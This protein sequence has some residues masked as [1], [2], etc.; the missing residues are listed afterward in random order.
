MRR[1]LYFWRE[2]CEPCKEKEP[3]VRAVAQE[4]GTSLVLIDSGAR[5]THE[6]G[7]LERYRVKAAPTVVVVDYRPSSEK[8]V[9]RSFGAFITENSLRRILER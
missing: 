1:I 3:L 6:E 7:L 8:I 9:G 5:L 4:S 2:G